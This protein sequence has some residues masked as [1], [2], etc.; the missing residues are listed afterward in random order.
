MKFSCVYIEQ[1]INDDPRVQRILQSLPDLPRVSIDRYGEVFNRRSQNFRLQKK[2]P[3]LILAKKHGNLVLPTPSGYG[4]NNDPSFYFSHMLNC[5]YDC[6]YCF[7]QGMYQSANYVLFVNYEDFADAL[8]ATLNMQPSSAVFYSGYDCDSLALEP[9]SHFAEFF[10][11]WFS[12]NPEA[13]LEIRTKSTQIRKFLNFEPINNCVIAMSISPE[14]VHKQW[15]NKVPD[16]HKRLDALQKL[17]Q[18]GWPI[19]IRFEPLI[20]GPDFE[21]DYQDL[22]KQVFSK[23]DGEKIH[24]VSTG[25]FRMPASYFKSIVNLY[26]DENLF[27]R[28]YEQQDG[29]ISYSRQQESVMLAAV[30]KQLFRYVPKNLYY[31]C[32]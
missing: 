27:A 26:P 16:L 24:S 22:L 17:Q 25:M 10:I 4:F 29:Q 2:Q 20:E 15:E 14:K 9:L 11:D 31:R 5:V 19:A 32:G 23:L 3:A 21:S 8:S 12:H 28:S 6:R 13:T 7:L 1:E 18:Q 30:E